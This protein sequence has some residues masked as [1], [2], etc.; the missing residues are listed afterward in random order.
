[1]RMRGHRG[2]QKT[3]AFVLALVVAGA[4]GEIGLRVFLRYGASDEQV[5]RYGS[6]AQL[7]QR[8]GDERL[9]PHR[10]LGFVTRPGYER[11]PNRHNSR[12]FRGDEVVVPKPPGTTRIVCLG[13]STTYGGGVPDYRLSYPNLLQTL[14]REHLRPEIEVINAGVPGYSSL[15]SLINLQLRVLEFDPDLVLIYHGINET[16]SFG[17]SPRKNAFR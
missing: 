13:G 7:I 8:F 11:P 12:G 5:R 10:Y 16:R 2:I 17:A 14:L 15:E 3:A 1:M 6:L 4:A 9:I